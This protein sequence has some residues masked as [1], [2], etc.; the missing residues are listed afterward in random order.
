MNEKDFW[1][2]AM[3]FHGIGG[4]VTPVYVQF[5][6]EQLHLYNNIDLDNANVVGSI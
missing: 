3:V 5:S 1:Q 2:S 6:W 4:C